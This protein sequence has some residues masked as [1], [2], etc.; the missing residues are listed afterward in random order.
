MKMIERYGRY[1]KPH[2]ACEE[3]LVRAM[4]KDE[5]CWM[6]DFR[7]QLC[8]KCKIKHLC[9]MDKDCKEIKRWITMESIGRIY[10]EYMKQIII[11]HM[12]QTSVIY[13]LMKYKPNEYSETWWVMSV[14][15]G[16]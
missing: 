12:K 2:W 8:R 11:D 7:H 16:D 13:N 5:G 9:L 6:T 4:C 10:G 3:C 1:P 14:T 15:N